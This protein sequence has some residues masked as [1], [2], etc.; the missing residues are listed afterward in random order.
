VISSLS[1]V[2]Y[3]MAKKRSAEPHSHRK[4]AD[5]ERKTSSRA[6]WRFFAVTAVAVA[7]IACVYEKSLPPGEGPVGDVLR[8]GQGI[9]FAKLHVSGQHFPGTGQGLAAARAFAAGDV[10]MEVPRT[11]Q[12][13]IGDHNLP[14]Q[15]DDYQDHLLEGQ[16]GAKQRLVLAFLFESQNAKSPWKPFFESLP[17]QINNLVA[18]TEVHQ[19]A[20][21]NHVIFAMLENHAEL[22]TA[23]RTWIREAAELFSTVP[24][25]ADVQWA[26]AVVESRCH[27]RGEGRILAP[28][29][30]LANH[31]HDKRKALNY[32][33]TQNKFGQTVIQYVAQ[34]S[35]QK[36]EEVF[37]HYGQFSNIRLL[38]QYGFTIPSNPVLDRV[39]YA[40][41]EVASPKIFQFRNELAPKGPR[42][43]ELSENRDASTQRTL[44]Q[45]GGLPQLFVNCWRL[46]GFDERVSAEKAVNAG[47]FDDRKETNFS[48]LPKAWIERDAGIYDEIS[49]GCAK[50]RDS[51]S[52][53]A[54][55]VLKE[56]QTLSD[57]LSLQLRDGLL[58][59]IEA[60]DVCVREMARQAN[61]TRSHVHDGVPD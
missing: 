1:L 26:I 9:R 7:L 40:L 33:T 43:S 21:K 20:L 25:D 48:V 22:L 54:G 14:S 41:F 27:M 11:E 31:H 53:E 51:Y 45:P 34:E 61:F 15:F 37:C 32:I 3:Q 38:V 8:Y 28:F 4:N 59:E 46:N 23:T 2:K 39:P 50:I 47:M 57:A 24:T 36:G 42:C 58:A 17:R 13:F 6:S 55:A 19:R 44:G 52:A 29:A 30:A 56:L 12:T 60:W 10:V 18:M 35:I 16:L 5:V 49:K